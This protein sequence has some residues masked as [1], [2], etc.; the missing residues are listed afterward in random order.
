LND[1]KT[2]YSSNSNF[3][4]SFPPPPPA[5]NPF[6]PRHGWIEHP[7]N[8]HGI[9]A[10]VAQTQRK[11]MMN[12]IWSL[13]KEV[14]ELSEQM[15]SEKRPKKKTKT[16]STSSQKPAK[17]AISDS[18]W[19]CIL[20]NMLAY[21]GTKVQQ[22]QAPLFLELVESN[23]RTPVQRGSVGMETTIDCGGRD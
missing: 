10:D 7:S 8:V 4:A 9:A 18:L 20:K 14:A 2:H 19:S 15:G 22:G 23:I 17:L 6:E 3:L 1:L 21:K 12:A 13:R 5:A 16:Q 11:A